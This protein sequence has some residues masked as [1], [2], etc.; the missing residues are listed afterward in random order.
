MKIYSRLWKKVCRYKISS[1]LCFLLWKWV[2]HSIRYPIDFLP[3]SKRERETFSSIFTGM[4]FQKIC[5]LRW[6]PDHFCSVFR[7]QYRQNRWKYPTSKKGLI[8]R[9][10]SDIGSRLYVTV[11]RFR[12]LRSKIR[13]FSTL[14]SAA[15]HRWQ[16]PRVTPTLIYT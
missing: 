3:G 14:F 2:F 5:L 10:L 15:D 4:I 11:R 1:D 9:L 8:L 7:I 13:L 16:H 12:F 6:G